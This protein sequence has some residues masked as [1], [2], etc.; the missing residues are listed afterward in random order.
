MIE[1][2][3]EMKWVVMTTSTCGYWGLSIGSPFLGSIA[4]DRFGTR[5]YSIKSWSD[6]IVCFG[7]ICTVCSN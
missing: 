3:R 2:L 7:G 4:G 6:Q 1:K 5:M